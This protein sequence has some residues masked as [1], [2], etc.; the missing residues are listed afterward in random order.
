MTVLILIRHASNDYIKEGRLAGW[1]PGVHI[2]AQG[3]READELARRLAHLPIEA[4]YASPLERAVDTANAISMCLHLP[5]E[6]REGLG[7]GHV[8]EWTGKTIKELQDT[9]IW[10][11][12]Q[13]RPVGVKPPGGESIEQVQARMV[14]EID[15]IRRAHP[16]GLVAIVS[17]ADPLKAAISHYLDWDLNQFQRIV[18]S[19]A[20]ASVLAVD[21]EKS[22]LLLLNHTGDIPKFEK[23]KPATTSVNASKAADSAESEAGKD[24]TMTEANLLY[25]LNP[26]TRVMTGALGEPGHRVF[27]LQ[28]RQGTL[29]VTLQAEKEQIASLG[30]GIKEM[31]ERL[32]RRAAQAEPV[33][34]YDTALEEPMEPLFHI[35]Q[36][37]LGFDK[38]HD[39]LVIVAYEVTEQET[40]E[41]VN[42]VRFWG[43][44]EQMRALAEHAAEVVAGGRPICVLCGKPIDPEG[45][46]CPRRNGHGANAPLA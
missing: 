41:S 17:H 22:G 34:P 10:K 23:P 6:I 27:Y 44:R 12:M 2:N 40:P 38:E 32:A 9:E 19:P 31:L 39:L 20:S 8:G 36:L 30:V 15:S 16:D 46:F 14:S 3:Q 25:D 35:G 29:L 42:Y 43:T 37:G 18:I 1:T 21:G 28:A 7:E 33:S 24:K 4:I 45:H 26:I 11:A 13:K 5:V